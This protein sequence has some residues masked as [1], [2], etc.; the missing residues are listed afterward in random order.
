MEFILPV[1]WASEVSREAAVICRLEL[2]SE[3]AENT[4]LHR[5]S[6]YAENRLSSEIRGGQKKRF[7]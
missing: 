4:M 7:I 5:E 3:R 6:L 2:L 1:C